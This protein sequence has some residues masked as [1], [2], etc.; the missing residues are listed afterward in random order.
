MPKIT[1]NTDANTAMSIRNAHAQREPSGRFAVGGSG[2]YCS[3]RV[4]V[5]STGGSGLGQ[6][7]L[8]ARSIVIKKLSVA[9]PLNRGFQLPSRFFFAEMFIQQIL[10]KLRR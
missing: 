8:S 7:Q 9:A 2:V 3:G 4:A 5:V 6:R 1:A 10:K